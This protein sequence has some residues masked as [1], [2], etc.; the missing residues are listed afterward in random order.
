MHT[1][2]LKNLIAETS[3]DNQLPAEERAR[4]LI[5]AGADTGE[6]LLSAASY[7]R[8]E[9]MRWLIEYGK[10]DVNFTDYYNRTPLLKAISDASRY[11]NDPGCIQLLLEHG[12]APNI[13]EKYGNSPLLATNNFELIRLL[14]QY[15][16][17]P[18]HQ[19]YKGTT[20]LMNNIK[21][22]RTVECLL[23]HEANPD[24]QNSKGQTALMLAIEMG[25]LDTIALLLAH[26]RSIEI[27]DKDN[28]TAA[29]YALRCGRRDVFAMLCNRFP[30]IEGLYEEE[31]V[32]L[33]YRERFQKPLPIDVNEIK[34]NMSPLMEAVKA[35]DCLLVEKLLRAEANVNLRARN[36]AAA[37]DYV[38][39]AEMVRLLFQYDAEITYSRGSFSVMYTNPISEIIWKKNV[40]LLE[41]Y[42]KNKQA[43]AIIN[44]CSYDN[45]SYESTPLAEA[46]K[47]ARNY[48]D[49]PDYVAFV[50]LLLEAGADPLQRINGHSIFLTPCSEEL[51]DLMN[52]A[53]KSDLKKTIED[54]NLDKLKMIVE[55]TGYWGTGLQYLSTYKNSIVPFDKASQNQEA[56]QVWLSSQL[57]I[58]Q[59]F[60]FMHN[61]AASEGLVKSLTT[62]NN[63]QSQA[64]HLFKSHMIHSLSNLIPVPMTEE[65]TLASE[66]ILKMIQAGEMTGWPQYRIRQMQ[67]SAER[68]Q[69]LLHSVDSMCQCVNELSKLEITGYQQQDA[70]NIMKEYIETILPIP[71]QHDSPGMSMS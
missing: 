65:W 8:I 22:P 58:Y 59:A 14:L 47:L 4:E 35:D 64:R 19:D 61:L 48:P 2:K 6:C 63:Y 30:E 23:Q 7:H 20:C 53:I 32:Q 12:A 46:L 25:Q 29:Q 69:L 15:R 28:Q 57:F 3:H 27:C 10:A 16:A 62:F 56:Y 70:W 26:T 24:L 11:Q 55:S 34:N 9:F 40:T 5:D 33:L 41:E 67:L 52:Q 21:N 54:H 49:N 42:L 36:G 13:Y 38:N 43:R 60:Y 68:E 39:S 18:N 51:N 66:I 45:F 37:I 17:D 44:H 1:D 50:R 31:M 71:E